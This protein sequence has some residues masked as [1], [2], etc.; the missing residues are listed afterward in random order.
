LL[1]SSQPRSWDLKSCT[2][3]YFSANKKQPRLKVPEHLPRPG[4]VLCTYKSP[5]LLTTLGGRY[6]KWNQ[7]LDRKLLLKGSSHLP[8]FQLVNGG[9]GI[10]P[11]KFTKYKLYWRHQELH[12]QNKVPC[13]GMSSFHHG[14]WLWADVSHSGLTGPFSLPRALFLPR[15]SG[16]A[17][18]WL[19]IDLC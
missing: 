16:S 7:F 19:L 12:R 2:N 1:R 5:D 17:S 8:T 6:S 9:A 18:L 11:R 13:P 15:D 4:T 3:L 14:K 10:D